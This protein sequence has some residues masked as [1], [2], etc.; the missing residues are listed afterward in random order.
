MFLSRIQLTDGIRQHSQLGRVLQKSSYGMHSLLWDLFPQGERFLFREESSAEQLQ[1][2]NN[3]PLYYV[4]SQYEPAQ[5]SPLFDIQTKAFRPALSSGDTL[6]FKLRANPTVSRQVEGKRLSQRHDVMMDAQRTWLL[7]A[8]AKRELVPGVNLT[9]GALKQLLLRHEPGSSS[10][11]ARK[12]E[13]ELDQVME[14]AAAEW[15]RS[16]GLRHGFEIGAV[17]CTGYR[18]HAL[19]EKHRQAGFSSVDY[20]GV[21][22]VTDPALFLQTLAAGLGPSKAF[23]CGL[24]LVRR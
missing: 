16:R 15:L 4:L 17:Q 3:R 22:T 13:H 2:P 6:H 10:D 19:P 8:C 21:L 20:D 12:L 24:L 9:K 5:Q 23:G 1:A 11:A 18:W 7:D 14:S